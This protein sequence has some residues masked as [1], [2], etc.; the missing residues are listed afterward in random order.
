MAATETKMAGGND[1][2]KI[3]TSIGGAGAETIY[4]GMPDTLSLPLPR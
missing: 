3:T 2:V 4:G 1:S